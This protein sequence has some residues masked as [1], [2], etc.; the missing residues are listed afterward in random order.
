MFVISEFETNKSEV[1]YSVTKNFFIKI[2]L[3]LKK[4]TCAAFDRHELGIC[5]KVYL[6]LKVLA[7]PWQK[8]NKNLPTK[9]AKE[10]KLIIYCS[11]IEK[12]FC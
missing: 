3:N 12:K 11:E 1:L 7:T 4:I 5:K 8:L 2:G 10:N 9:L 6:L